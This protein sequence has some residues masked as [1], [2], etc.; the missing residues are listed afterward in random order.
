[1][2][3]TS[4]VRGWLFIPKPSTVVTELELSAAQLGVNLHDS[5]LVMVKPCVKNDPAGARGTTLQTQ[6]VRGPEGQAQTCSALRTLHP[7]SRMGPWVLP[8]RRIAAEASERQLQALLLQGFSEPARTCKIAPLLYTAPLANTQPQRNGNGDVMGS[9]AA[10]A[11][12]ATKASTEESA[13]VSTEGVAVEVGKASPKDA[14]A[15]SVQRTAQDVTDT[16]KDVRSTHLQA[17]E[18]HNSLTDSLACPAQPR[19]LTTRASPRAHNRRRRRRPRASPSSPPGSSPCPS[20]SAPS[21][22]P[23]AC[24]PR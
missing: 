13:E 16:E 6:S 4:L 8:L 20:S 18:A 7:C 2:R 12:G 3:V 5:W 14:A 1:M 23:S 10:G 15:F 17:A 22:P 11:A 9:G 19:P 24:S 21:A